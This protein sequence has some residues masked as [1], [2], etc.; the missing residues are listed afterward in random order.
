MLNCRLPDTNAACH[1]RYGRS[2]WALGLVLL[3]TGCATTPQHPWQA[4]SEEIV[5]PL[6]PSPP[7]IRYEGSIATGQLL[8]FR[9]GFLSWML[10][11][12]A[13]KPEVGLRVPHGLATDT[14]LLVIADSASGSLHMFDL[15][16]RRYRQV[17]SAGKVR[18]RC[19]IGV[20]L[21]GQGG[22]FVTDSALAR[23][24]HLSRKGKLLGE[25]QGPFLRPTG[26]AYDQVR[27]QLH[28]VDT[29]AHVVLTF[30]Q[31]P[32]G[33]TQTRVLGKRGE[34]LGMFNFPTHIALDAQANL[35]VSDSLNFR[36]QTFNA[37]GRRIGTF[38]QV[39]DGVGDFA[40][41]KGVAVDKHGHVYVV[42][43]LFDVVQIFDQK[44][45]FLLSFGGSG[46]AGG[47]LWLPTGICTDEEDRIYVADSGN[48]RVQVF[49]LLPQSN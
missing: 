31:G 25:I 10:D 33:F 22:V 32:R 42:D 1:G 12:F 27:G 13:G 35:Y 14:E 39:G 11:T 3:A 6:P 7:R 19:P 5:W 16:H 47:S 4:T 2:A 23:V 44:G 48:Q 24:F 41:P 30:E 9:K 17:E 26:L 8:K 21:D 20:A 37:D 28:V 36:I 29:G 40:K 38:G 34:T 46:R 49:R 15:R 45:R 43:S 18:L